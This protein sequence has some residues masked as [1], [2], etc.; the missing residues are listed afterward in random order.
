MRVHR[1]DLNDVLICLTQRSLKRSEYLIHPAL[2]LE[3]TRLPMQNVRKETKCDSC[4]CYITVLG[5]G[6]VLSHTAIIVTRK[7]I[8]CH[9]DTMHKNV[10]GGGDGLQKRR[11]A[12]NTRVYPKV[13]GL[14]A[15]NQ[16]CKWQS[17]VPIRAVVSLFCELV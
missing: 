17:S 8:L 13:A 10:A 12:A 2:E 15:W 9:R 3:L 16:N 11:V 6:Y 5:Q 1:Q 7:L 4:T 14:A